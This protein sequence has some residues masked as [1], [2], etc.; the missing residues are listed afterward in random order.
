[1][2]A[3]TS[4]LSF[5]LVIENSEPF[6]PLT[7][8]E[9]HHH[10]HYRRRRPAGNTI[11][12]YQASHSLGRACVNCQRNYNRTRRRRNLLVVDHSI[13]AHSACQAAQRN[14]PAH[15]REIAAAS[16]LKLIPTRPINSIRA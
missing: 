3:E 10:L 12:R 7:S 6:C 11:S 5:G 13:G 2:C 14:S 15:S 9:L 8:Y 16:W 1:M 4:R